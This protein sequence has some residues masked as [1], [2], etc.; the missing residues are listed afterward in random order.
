[1]DGLWG[2]DGFYS[3]GLAEGVEEDGFVGW[4]EGGRHFSK[5]VWRIGCS[6]YI[7]TGNGNVA[8]YI[9]LNEVPFALRY[10]LYL[11]LHGGYV[12]SIGTI[13]DNAIMPL[14]TCTIGRCHIQMS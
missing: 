8:G 4:W 9:T 13:E 6:A 3:E 7:E 12:K 5:G 11:C 2:W 10:M 14:R 1:M